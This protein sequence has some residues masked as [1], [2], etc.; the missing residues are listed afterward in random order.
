MLMQ[1]LVVT[2]A[3][4]EVEI[5]SDALWGMGVVAV[6]ERAVGNVVELW[7][8][9][10]DDAD[11]ADV[12]PAG[13]FPW[14]W[15]FVQVDAGV[16]DTWRQ[17]ARPI[18]ISPTLVVRP[19]WVHYGG[20]GTVVHIE[21]GATF[22]MGDHPT[23]ILCLRAVER[24]T[25][26][27]IDVLD[28]GCGSGVL[29]IGAM[30]LGASKAVGVDIAPA[31]VPVT[32]A[33][34]EANHVEVEVSTTPLDQVDGQYDLGVANILAPA[35]VALAPHLRRLTRGSLVISGILAEAHDHVLEAL[36]PMKVVRTDT[37]DVWAA[38][39]LVN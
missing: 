18:V 39:T 30:V 29:A 26:T 36:A 10:G 15:R 9:L 25:T 2:V 34:A 37:L 22:G 16:A 17:F 1:Q 8:S 27:G 32:L 3:P 33:N 14:Q 24:L 13:S 23:T 38:V 5:A 19:A 11:A 20:P 4:A 35:L 21:P 12:W 31:A 6:E 7:T 28:V